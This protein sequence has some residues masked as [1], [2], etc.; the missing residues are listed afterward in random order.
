MCRKPPTTLP[1]DD[2]LCVYRIRLR[3]CPTYIILYTIHSP[4]LRINGERE[5]SWMRI[6]CR[7]PC[8][9]LS[10]SLARSLTLRPR[11]PYTHFAGNIRLH[12]RFACVGI[13]VFG[14][15][16]NVRETVNNRAHKRAPDDAFS[17]VF[18][19]SKLAFPVIWLQHAAD[20]PPFSLSALLLAALR[21]YFLLSARP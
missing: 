3:F 4:V 8:V 13:F 18:C 2:A 9:R 1:D 7:D 19:I 14:V 17:H 11:N 5:S 21:V 15:C 10:L 12:N 20:C 16:V 6:P